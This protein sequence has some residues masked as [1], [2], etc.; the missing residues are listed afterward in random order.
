M[1]AL[2]RAGR[3]REPRRSDGEGIWGPAAFSL[4]AGNGDD[5]M[6]GAGKRR[7]D[8]AERRSVGGQGVFGV[9]GSMSG[10]FYGLS[11]CGAAEEGTQ[12]AEPF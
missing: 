3:K 4:S 12:G 5:A 10:K 9:Q 11:D 8:W 2:K 1:E 7:V 6:E